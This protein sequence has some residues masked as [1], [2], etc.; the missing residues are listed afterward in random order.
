MQNKIKRPEFIINKTTEL[1]PSEKTK[2]ATA[3]NDFRNRIVAKYL[4][5]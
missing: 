1:T 3:F 4:T 2:I 5:D